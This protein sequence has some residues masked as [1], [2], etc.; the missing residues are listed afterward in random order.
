MGLLLLVESNL[1]S[2]RPP[3]SPLSVFVEQAVSYKD[4]GNACIAAGE[5]ASALKHYERGIKIVS[6]LSGDEQAAAL[7]VSLR[8]NLALACTKEERYFDAANAASKVLEV[9]SSNLKVC[10]THVKNDCA[11]SWQGVSVH[12]RFDGGLSYRERESCCNVSSKENQ[13]DIVRSGDHNPVHTKY[14]EISL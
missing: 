5:S 9:D 2:P 1:K 3:P 7:L 6:T 12:Q 13:C 4:R 8:L 10:D 14:V 11:A